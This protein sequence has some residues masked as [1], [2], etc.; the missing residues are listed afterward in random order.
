MKMTVRGVGN[1]RE[2]LYKEL[3]YCMWHWS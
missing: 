1:E 2:L 3:T